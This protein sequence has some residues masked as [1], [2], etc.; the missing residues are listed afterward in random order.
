MTQDIEDIITNFKNRSIL[1]EPEKKEKIYNLVEYLHNNITNEIS[2]KQYSNILEH[3]TITLEFNTQLY[4]TQEP[5][6]NYS[7]TF[8]DIFS[9]E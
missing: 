9:K 5:L 3:N 1:L 2:W 6:L 8:I 7:G 4:K